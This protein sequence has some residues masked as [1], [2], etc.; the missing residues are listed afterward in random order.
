MH[1]SDCWR[2]LASA[3]VLACLTACG[4]G[5]YPSSPIDQR[6][7]VLAE[8]TATTWVHI[9]DEGQSFTVSGT[10]TVRYGAQSSWV[11]KSVTS[12][13]QCTNAFFGSDPLNGVVKSC[14]RLS[15]TNQA[16]SATIAN[17]TAGQTFRAGQTVAFSGSATDPE[18]GSVPASRLTWWAELHHDT[19]THP[20]QPMTTG[21]SGSVTIPVRGETSDN[22]WYRFHLRATDSQGATNEVTRDLLPQKSHFTLSTQPAGL[23]LTLDGQPLTAPRTTTGVVG[24]ERDL[25]AADQDFNGRRYR[26]TRWSDGGAAMHTIATPAA[27]TTYVATFTDVGA[28]TNQPPAIALSFPATGTVNQPMTL[29]ATAS[30]SDGTVAK[31]EFFDGINWI[32][33]DT[34]NPYTLTWTPRSTGQHNLRARATDDD[35]AMKMTAPQY[36]TINGTTSDTTPPTVALT[37]PAKFASGLAGTISL[38]A[39]AS[40][41]VGVQSVEFQVD[42]MAAGAAD[43][44]SPYS[45]SFDT[46]KLASGQHVVRARA[47]DA[48]GNLSGW[49]SATVAFGG[50]RTLP[51]GFSRIMNWVTGLSGATAI[52]RASDGRFFVAEQGGHLRVVKN[53]ALLATPFVSLSVDSAGERGLIGVTLDP[54][55]A[56]NH[57]VYVYYTTT[58]NG[59]HNRISRF[60]ANGDVAVAGSELVLVNLPALS[61]ATNHN[62]GALHFGIDGKLYVGVGENASPSKAQNLA[63]PFGKLLRFNADGSIPTDNPFYASQTGLAR[64]V[65]AY[66]LRNPFTFAVQAGTGRIHI[67][68]VGQNTWEEINRGT[69]GANYGWPGSEGPDNVTAGITGPSFTYKHSATSPPGTGPGGFFTGFAIAGAAFYPDTGMFPAPYRGN[70]FFADYVSGFVALYDVANNAAYA[71]STGFTSPVDMAVGTDGALYVLTRSA[72]ARISSP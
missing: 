58:Q 37:A 14:E 18:D 65:W 41:N 40:D 46:N 68:D 26:F 30:D 1:R 7:A 24:M 34:N 15:T 42:G 64:A 51:Q 27:D 21:G 4:G 13:G 53:G 61:T 60:T 29:T 70:Y 6:Q 16:P 52:A 66:G 11:Q 67:N 59:A 12:S 54:N 9:A 19:H 25:G 57:F 32:G 72:L 56:T 43:T 8:A 45:V 63:D 20:F 71:F 28:A 55:F 50:T 48:A 5:G 36:V 2:G 39:T 10:Q 17:P 62:G 38:S 22:I 3:C 31:V 33:A 49:S 23:H 35:G 47:R 44:S 69:S